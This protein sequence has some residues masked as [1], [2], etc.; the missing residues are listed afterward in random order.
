MKMHLLM[1]IGILGLAAPIYA[2]ENSGS[3]LLKNCGATVKQ[4]DGGIL[5]EEESIGAVY[6]AGYL[7]GFVD[8]HVMETNAKPKKPLYCLPEDGIKNEQMARILTAYFKKHPERLQESARLHVVS[9]LI[10]NFPC[11]KSGGV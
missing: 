9:L 7:S 4:A 1:I 8:S 5:N 2:D 6:C 11:K 10:K 3:A